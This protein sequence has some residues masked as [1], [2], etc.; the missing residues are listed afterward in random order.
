MLALYLAKL[1]EFENQSIVSLSPSSKLY[2]LFQFVKLEIFNQ[3]ST[4]V[5]IDIMF[6]FTN[7]IDD[8]HVRNDFGR[9]YVAV[10]VIN[11]LINVGFSLRETYL[12]L[13]LRCFRRNYLKYQA[14][15]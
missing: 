15:Y 2:F 12:S 9:I 8:Y 10:I 13:K 4:V 6:V 1:S 3:V 7:W 5:I 11:L 14:K